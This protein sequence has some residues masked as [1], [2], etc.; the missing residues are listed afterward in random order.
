MPHACLLH[1]HPASHLSGGHRVHEHATFSHLVSATAAFQTS[2]RPSHAKPQRYLPINPSSSHLTLPIILS[3]QPPPHHLQLILLRAPHDS[4]LMHAHK[5]HQHAP[6]AAHQRRLP[7]QQQA[8]IEPEEQVPV[9]EEHQLQRVP[10][11][12]GAD[13]RGAEA[14]VGRRREGPDAEEHGARGMLSRAV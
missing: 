11:G 7:A 4:A 8:Q 5:L 1:C 3:K 14:G 13:A 2:R 6:A 10:L 9:P 12:G